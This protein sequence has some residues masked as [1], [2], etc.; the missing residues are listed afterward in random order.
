MLGVGGVARSSSSSYLSSIW[1]KGRRLATSVGY[2]SSQTERPKRVS[3]SSLITQ[4]LKVLGDLSKFR[5]S[6]L[7]VLTTS[8]GFVL[9]GSPLDVCT[10]IAASAGT[11][12]CAASASTF[13]QI[14]EIEND[15]RM[16]RTLQRPIPSG[17][18]TPS[19][20]GLWGGV[21]GISGVS[22]LYTATNPAV[23]A[24]GA[25]NIFL[26]AGL[27]TYSK[28]Y[29][30]LNTWLGSIVGAIPPVMGWLAATHSFTLPQ[31]QSTIQS[32]VLAQLTI[33]DPLYFP[34]L[35]QYGMFITGEPLTLATLLFLWQFPHFFA[36]S[37]L[38]RDD[39]IRGNFQMIA[40]NDPYGQRTANYIL[41]YSAYLTAFPILTSVLGYTSY[42]YSIEGTAANIYLL[43][44]ASRFKQDQSN[45]NARR[46]FLC[47]LWYLPLLLAG[48]VFHSRVWNALTDDEQVTEKDQLKEALMNVKETGKGLCVHER[49]AQ[50]D[51]LCLKIASDQV[52]YIYIYSMNCTTVALT[53]LG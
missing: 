24:L 22:F 7:V 23:A 11:G 35:A 27:Y 50:R 5:L 13:N 38:Y 34:S 39:Y 15:S 14:I 12:L 41:E 48:F 8:A 18:I 31:A 6:S 30:E 44:L 3:T 32:S 45:S 4:H 28:R 36:L 47:S 21:T 25:L 19:L 26:Y 2:F 52:Q 20:A 1:L 42:M 40:C 53:E 9:A 33:S 51:H 43:Y 49:M 29:T 17:K 10:L 16:K 46:I 37:W